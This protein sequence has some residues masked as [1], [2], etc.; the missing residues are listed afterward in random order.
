MDGLVEGEATID[1]GTDLD[2]IL[3][4]AS[5]ATPFGHGLRSATRFLGRFEPTMVCPEDDGVQASAASRATM[6]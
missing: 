6:I 4:A 1:C 2:A 5:L 3:I